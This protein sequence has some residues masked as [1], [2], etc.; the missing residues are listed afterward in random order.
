MLHFFSSGYVDWN[1]LPEDGGHA[2]MTDV[3]EEVPTITSSPQV[4]TLL[5]TN[6]CIDSF[7][8]IETANQMLSNQLDEEYFAHKLRVESSDTF[9]KMLSTQIYSNVK[10]RVGYNATEPLCN[11]TPISSI[12]EYMEKVPSDISDQ[13]CCVRILNSNEK[14]TIGT[15]TLQTIQFIK[16]GN[17][18]SSNAS[19]RKFV[20]NYSK[21]I[22]PNP[23]ILKE[24]IKLFSKVEDKYNRDVHTLVAG[25]Q[26]LMHMAENLISMIESKRF[27]KHVHPRRVFDICA[28]DNPKPYVQKTFDEAMQV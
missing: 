25:Q 24:M 23:P 8:K 5:C 21:P 10:F 12:D 14:K 22:V 18:D 20:V 19:A 28:G 17:F 1:S 2:L 27:S 11:Y 4:L 3:H 15:S 7:D 16:A 13:G 9:Q 6:D 26:H